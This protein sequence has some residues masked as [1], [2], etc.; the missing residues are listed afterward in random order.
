MSIYLYVKTHN[1]TGLK[2]FGKTTKPDPHKYLGSGKYWKRHIK[3]H[4]NDITTEIVG[5]FDSAEECQEFAL[6]FSKQNNIVD[7]EL[8]ANLQEE[9]GL[10]GAP[11]G[12]IGHKFTDEQLNQISETTKQRWQDQE[13]RNKIIEK[14]K[15]SW[16]DERKQKQI[17]RLTG[18]KRP[19]H[20]AKLMGHEG[21]KK[22][23]GVKKPE[24]HGA[25]VSASLKGIP[26]SDEHRLKLSAPKNRVCR[27]TDRKEMSVNHFSRWVKSLLV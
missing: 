12:H 1:A 4:G 6:K 10:D 14:Q 18:K 5:V 16:T 17:E 13:Y 22:C 19:E 26:K 9:N 8:W 2:Y 24:G 27:L 7:S 15:Q 3:K 20:S 11:Q 21:T 25:K 23:K